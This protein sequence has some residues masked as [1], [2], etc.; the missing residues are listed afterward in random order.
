MNHTN[1][2]QEAMIIGKADTGIGSIDRCCKI[3]FEVSRLQCRIGANAER[4]GE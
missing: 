2:A 3:T 1:N 4:A